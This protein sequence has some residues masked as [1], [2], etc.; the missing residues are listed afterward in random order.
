LADVYV[1]AVD[2]QKPA[3]LGMPLLLTANMPRLE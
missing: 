2:Q 3:A 1:Q